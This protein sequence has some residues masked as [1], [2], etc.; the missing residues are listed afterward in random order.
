[1]AL[2][3]HSNKNVSSTKKIS[4]IYIIDSVVVPLILFLFF[5]FHFTISPALHI[6]HYHCSSPLLS[7]IES[8]DTFIGWFCLLRVLHWTWRLPKAYQ[9]Y[10]GR[11]YLRVPIQ[12]L[13]FGFFFASIFARILVFLIRYSGLALCLLPTSSSR[14]SKALFIFVSYEAVHTG[15][16]SD[17][18]KAFRGQMVVG[19]SHRKSGTFCRLMLQ[20]NYDPERHRR[21]ELPIISPTWGIFI[22]RRNLDRSRPSHNVPRR[23]RKWKIHRCHCIYT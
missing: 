19:Y 7:D 11:V 15:S 4:A 18:P 20:S 23:K 17:P 12:F 9:V 21:D 16:W 2:V 14:V 1:M 13:F 22:V 8:A 10:C 5:C 3:L 6:F